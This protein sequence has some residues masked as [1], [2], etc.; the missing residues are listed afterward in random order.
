MIACLTLL[1]PEWCVPRSKGRAAAILGLM[2]SLPYVMGWRA[3]LGALALSRGGRAAALIH[4]PSAGG[5]P[6]PPS[7]GTVPGHYFLKLEFA[8]ADEEV[9][10]AKWDTAQNV[11]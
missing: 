9:V 3:P 2:C 4:V 8:V 10:H 5:D 7:N 1:F 11:Q 6:W